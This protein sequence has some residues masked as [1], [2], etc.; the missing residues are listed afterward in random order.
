MLGIHAINITPSLVSKLCTVDEFK[1]LWTGLENHTTGLQ[2]LADVAEYGA[3]LSRVLGPL[4]DHPITPQM[5]KTLHASLTGSKDGPTD[6]KSVMEPLVFEKD[7]TPVGFLDTAAPEEVGPLMNKLC[8]WVNESLERED[9]HPLLTLSAFTAVFLQIAPFETGNMRAARFLAILVMLKAGY[10][11][12]PY[13]PLDKIMEEKSGEVYRAL[14][15][16]QDSLNAGRP[17]WAEWLECFLDILIVQKQ[18]LHK[19]LYAEEKS[20]KNLPT[21]SAKILK[22]FEN[23]KRLQMKEII[24]LTN[25]RRSTIKLRLGELVDGGYLKRHGQARSTWYALV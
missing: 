21:L 3:N 13:V 2:L 17:S 1:G 10:S 11:Y 16:N 5:I 8:E 23:H 6:F 14:K 7:E 24:K 18:T 20:F 22:L 12:A 15:N 25:G 4:R 9:F 19:R